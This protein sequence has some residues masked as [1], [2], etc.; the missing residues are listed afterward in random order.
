VNCS[1]DSSISTL[2]ELLVIYK[3]NTQV[4]TKPLTVTLSDQATTISTLCLLLVQPALR[5]Y[6]E[7]MRFLFDITAMFIDEMMSPANNNTVPATPIVSSSQGAFTFDS[8]PLRA[9]TNLKSEVLKFSAHDRVVNWLLSVPKEKPDAWLGLCAPIR[10]TN[11]KPS[12]SG[13]QQQQSFGSQSSPQQQGSPAMRPVAGR[14]N[15]P[16]Q[17]SAGSQPQTG[18]SNV[19]G[20][21]QGTTT[22]GSTG[23]SIKQF[24][25]P[26]PFQVKNWDLLPDQG[27]IAGSANDTAISLSL[28]G[29]RKV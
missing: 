18:S 2:L 25:P 26:I 24:G 11:S 29:T 4:N 13:L 23:S 21:S 20:L 17:R 12:Q 10:D 22:G 6:A 15:I 19:G 27:S 16:G 9:L 8:E 28:F 3:T 5:V 7:T 14:S 1:N